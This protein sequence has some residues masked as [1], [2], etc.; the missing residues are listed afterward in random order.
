MAPGSARS[1]SSRSS[2]GSSGVNRLQGN[3]LSNSGSADGE[4]QSARRLLG[5]LCVDKLYLEQLLKHPGEDLT[6]TLLVR[7]RPAAGT[8]P[9]ST[10]LL[11]TPGLVINA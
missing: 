9:R 3:N 8:T 7:R 6:N 10:A 4:E 5:E 2:R 11:R 1:Q